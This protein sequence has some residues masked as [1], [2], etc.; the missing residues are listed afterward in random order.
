MTFAGTTRND[1]KRLRAAGLRPVALWLPD[2]DSAEFRA[3]CAHESAALRHDAEE[4]AVL[5]W[6]EEVADTTG[7]V[8]NEEG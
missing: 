5:E 2:A 7:W 1:R 6:I 3:E 8:W 4:R